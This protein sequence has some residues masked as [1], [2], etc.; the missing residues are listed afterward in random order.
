MSNLSVRG[1]QSTS[2]EI[3]A[4]MNLVLLATSGSGEFIRKTSSTTFENATPAAGSSLNFSD[5]ETPSG[6]INSSNT[7]FTLANSPSPATSLILH[8][9]G[10]ILT[11]GVE[12]TLSG[13]TI[14]F[15]TAPDELFSGLP[16]KA[17][18]RY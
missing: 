5:S 10:Q 2:S 13:S 17:W 6:T 3:T 18:Y 1:E 4:L 7:V 12:Y 9:N 14:T 16:F 8:L 11:Q 15:A